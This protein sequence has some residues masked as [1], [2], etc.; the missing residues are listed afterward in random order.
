[1]W[2]RAGIALFWRNG[3]DVNL[4]AISKYFIDVVNTSVEG[5]WRFRSMYREP[6]SEKKDITSRALRVLNSRPG[7]WLCMDDFN[8]ILFQYEKQGGAARPQRCMDKFREPLEECGLADLGYSRYMFTWHNH[9]QITEGYIQERLDRAVANLE[10]RD[11]FL[12]YELIN[13]E[14]RHSDHIPIILVLEGSHNI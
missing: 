2:E 13:G 10:W 9:H 4:H 5:R 8:E 7:P 6:N 1:V 3:I 14:Q 12:R 11:L